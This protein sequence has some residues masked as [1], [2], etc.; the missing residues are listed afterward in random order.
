MGSSPLVV[1][2]RCTVT[3]IIKAFA[4]TKLGNITKSESNNFSWECAAPIIYYHCKG[5]FLLCGKYLSVSPKWKM[6]SPVTWL[7]HFLPHVCGTHPCQLGIFV[8]PLLVLK[9]YWKKT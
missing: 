7:F 3:H 8:I 1:R 5:T 4:P 9:I 6:V 2:N